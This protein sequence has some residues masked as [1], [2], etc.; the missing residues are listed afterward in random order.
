MSDE[1]DMSKRVVHYQTWLSAFMQNR[2]EVDKSLLTISSLFMGLL[3]YNKP[4]QSSAFCLWI[5][6]GFF[7]TFTI[8]GVL[9]TFWTNANFAENVLEQHQ[10]EMEQKNKK[11]KYLSFFTFLTFVVAIVLTFCSAIFETW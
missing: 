6:S 8:L 4:D 7:F 11:L 2:M 9:I 1:E 10:E 3:F 5:L